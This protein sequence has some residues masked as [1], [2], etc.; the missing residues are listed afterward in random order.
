M[1]TEVIVALITSCGAFVSSGVVALQ[2]ARATR[3]QKEAE[4]RLA[5]IQASERKEL[6]ASTEDYRARLEIVRSE[7]AVALERLKADT[8]LRLE[9]LRLEGER[10][11][12]AFGIATQEVALAENSIAEA[13]EDIQI[14][15]EQISILSAPVRHSTTAALRSLTPATERLKVGYAKLGTRLPPEA[16]RAWHSAKGLA[17]GVVAEISAHSVSESEAPRFPEEIMTWLQEA[18]ALLTDHQVVLVAA[19]QQLREQHMHKVLELL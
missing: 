13:F 16:R 6:N 18:R 5:R 1:T 10:R 3:Q 14:V 7:Y 12:Q 11:R 8:S 19:Q 2:N 4:E 15:K 9:T 17:D